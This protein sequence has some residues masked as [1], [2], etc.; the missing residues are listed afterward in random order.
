M[1]LWSLAFLA[2]SETGV[3]AVP[4][5]EV[6]P[7]EEDPLPIAEEPGE[8]VADA[9]PDQEKAPLENVA[10]NGSRSADPEGLE[11]TAYAWTLVSAPEG[12]T[13]DLD[14]P[15]AV[16]PSFFADLAGEYVFELTVENEKGA[17]DSSPDTVTIT[18]LPLDGFYV[19]LSWDAA[20]DLDL[21][22]M[23]G[24]AGL[25]TGGDCNF[26]NATPAWKNPGRIDDP[27]LDIDAIDGFGPETT[28]IDAPSA[29][30]YEVAVHYYGENGNTRCVG[31]CAVS[32]ATVRLYLGGVLVE[33]F[34]QTMNDQGQ[35]WT[36]AQIEWPSGRITEVGDLGVTTKTSCF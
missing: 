28:T 16:K 35:L 2:C 24:S 18:V 9:G 26:C 14:D 17:W 12:S 5:P 7:D 32:Q 3:R 13:T 11:I 27:S 10:L 36:V 1:S 21:H 6:A 19:E 30:T 4:Q 25:F 33:T 15:T 23:D 20:N 34:R 29:G 22:L 8:P 31:A